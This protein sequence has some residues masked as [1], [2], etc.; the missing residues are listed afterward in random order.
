MGQKTNPNIFRLGINKTWKTDFFEKKNKEL[1]NYIF[2]DLEIQSFIERFF[3]LYNLLIHDY[4]LHYSNSV[5]NIYISYFITPTFTF[6]TLSKSKRLK[7]ATKKKIKKPVIFIN[8]CYKKTFNKVVT[9]DQNKSKLNKN[10]TTTFTSIK[11]IKIKNYLKFQNNSQQKLKR[12]LSREIDQKNLHHLKLQNILKLF[13]E[14]LSFFIGRKYHITTTFNCLNNELNLTEKQSK[15]FKKKII[16]LQKFKNSAIF[17]EGLEI[18]FASVFYKKSSALLVKFIA[19]QI[20]KTKRHNF[21]LAFLKRT[22]TIFIYSNFSKVDGIKIIIK[23]KLNN[24]PRA[25]HKILIIGNVPVQTINIPMDYSQ[26]TTHNPNG[27]YGIKVWIIE[28][29]KKIL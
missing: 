10:Q 29:N 20:K 22:L 2:K 13:V 7:L 8:N 28:K 5:I 27:S 6:N 17:K 24:A 19:N 4:K 14:S 16:F 18:L 26:M 21:L 15:S 1:P 3:E 23:G 11:P 25:R 12:Q 9:R